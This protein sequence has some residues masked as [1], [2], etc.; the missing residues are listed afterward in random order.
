M[1]FVCLF[2]ISS[3][4]DGCKNNVGFLY[5][6]LR[7]HTSLSDALQAQWSVPSSASYNTSI[8]LIWE[9]SNSFRLSILVSR[10][11]FQQ[12]LWHLYSTWVLDMVVGMRLKGQMGAMR[13]APTWWASLNAQPS[14]LYRTTSPKEEPTWRE[15]WQSSKMS[16]SKYIGARCIQSSGTQHDFACDRCSVKWCSPYAS[17]IIYCEISMLQTT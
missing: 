3:K 17:L 4:S 2:G 15:I 11:V 16:G 6:F 14:L 9:S 12:K 8:W 13:L 7:A 1:C 5:L 10:P